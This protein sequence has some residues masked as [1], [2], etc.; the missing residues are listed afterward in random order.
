MVLTFVDL[1]AAYDSVNR[2]ALFRAMD[3]I[4]LGGK[5]QQV[6]GSLYQNDRIIFEVNNSSTKPLHLTQGVRQ[7][8][9]LLPTLFNILLKQVADQLQDSL[10]GVELDGE[11]ISILLYADDICLISSSAKMA[12]E[13]YHLLVKVCDQVGMKINQSKSQIVKKGDKGMD[14]LQDIPHEQVIVY[15]Y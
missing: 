8:C 4:G 10:T 3:A 9:N 12:K 2:Q 14:I 5:V 13:A 6:I 7:G 15:K 11:V 1:S